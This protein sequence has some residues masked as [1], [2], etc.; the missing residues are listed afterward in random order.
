MR[1]VSTVE[2]QN[3]RFLF[4][5]D[6]VLCRQRKCSVV[7]LRPT[8]LWRK[9][10][11][12]S[13]VPRITGEKHLRS[14]RSWKGLLIIW[15]L[16]IICFVLLSVLQMSSHL[17]YNSC[18]YADVTGLNLCITVIVSCCRPLACKNSACSF[19]WPEVIKGVPNQDIVVLLAIT[20]SAVCLRCM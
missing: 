2:L 20:V 13:R 15:C 12:C 5:C 10:S 16:C 8:I 11:F 6:R 1:V 18:L 7:L 9:F 19:S 3:I 14:W 4:E 17:Y